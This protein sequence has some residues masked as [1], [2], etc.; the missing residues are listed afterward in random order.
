M[1]YSAGV[2]LGATL[3][4]WALVDW[5]GYVEPRPM[6]APTALCVAPF[7]L[8]SCWRKLRR[9]LAQGSR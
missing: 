9:G 1:S 5:H 7:L 3:I 8:V 2:V 4:T 6:R